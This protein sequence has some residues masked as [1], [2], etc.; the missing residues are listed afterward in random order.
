MSGDDTWLP[1]IADPSTCILIA[2][3]DGAATI[4]ATIDRCRLQ[5]DVYVVSDG[6]GDDTVEVARRHGAEVL[7]LDENVGKPNAIRVAYDHF[8]I[9]ERYDTLL[10][11]A[12]DTRLADDFVASATA[13][14]DQGVAVVCG[15]TGSDWMHEVR[16]NGLV[17]ARALA[18]W[19]YGLF[20]KQGQHVLNAITVIPG[21][22]SIFRTE[23]M[24]ELLRREV[25]YIVDDTQWLLDIQTEG[26]GRVVYERTPAPTSRI[27][28]RC[29]RG[30]GRR[31]VGST[32]RCRAFAGIGSVDD[33]AGSRWRTSP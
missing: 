17:G 30:I 28:P 12:D 26:M 14:F 16:W 25:R 11:L 5:A 6:S 18:Y 22:N 9:A 20:V 13:K 4:G 19:R 33:S 24:T 3:K 2:S 8:S 21:S 15:E 31:S 10:I 1:A 29:G 23:V 7:G 27:R 32:R